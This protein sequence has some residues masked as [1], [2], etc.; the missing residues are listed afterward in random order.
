MKPFLLFAALRRGF[1][2][3]AESLFSAGPEKSN[4]KRGPRTPAIWS[5]RFGYMPTSKALAREHAASYCLGFLAHVQTCGLA[6]PRPFGSSVGV[7]VPVPWWSASSRS[8]LLKWLVFGHSSLVTF[9]CASRRKRSFGGAKVTR[10]P[11][12]N[13]AGCSERQTPPAGAEHGARSR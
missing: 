13:P 1:V 2:P 11:G 4:Q 12:R 5:A 10:Q 8:E 9:F 7:L 6:T 3:A